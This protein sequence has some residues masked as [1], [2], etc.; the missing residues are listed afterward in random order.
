MI[1][2]FLKPATVLMMIVI[3]LSAKAQVREVL[4]AIKPTK[5]YDGIPVLKKGNGV[6]QAG[7]GL[8]SN[9]ISILNQ[10]GLTSVL[11]GSTTTKNTGPFVISYEY[12]VKDNLGL[13]IG[14]SYAE[15]NQTVSIGNSI[16]GIPL[17][18]A[19]SITK[20]ATNTA[21]FAST[22]YHMYTT[23][24]LDPYTRV[25]IGLNIWKVIF[26]DQ[27]GADQPV[28]TFPTPIAYNAV[29]G[30]RYFATPQ[31]GLFGEASYSNLRLAANAGITFKLH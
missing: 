27:S 31:V 14:F 26:K 21:I 13:G 19:T 6:V 4:E 10:S 17:G 1:N 23:N 9:L 11:N 12:L 15:T 24:K 18:T 16:L 5:A 30:L 7:V 22:T 3:G 25:S 28:P 20:K 8:G 29:V 2:K